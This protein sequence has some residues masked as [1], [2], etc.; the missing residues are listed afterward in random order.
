VVTGDGVLGLK[1]V[2]FEGKKDAEARDFLQGHENFRGSL[3]PS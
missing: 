1:R 3:L 2:Q